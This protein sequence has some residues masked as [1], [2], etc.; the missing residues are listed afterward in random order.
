MLNTINY[1]E[2]IQKRISENLRSFKLQP[3]EK[4]EEN[5]RHE[6]SKILIINPTIKFSMELMQFFLMVGKNGI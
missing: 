4:Q 1:E 6:N 3:L 2:Q 5:F